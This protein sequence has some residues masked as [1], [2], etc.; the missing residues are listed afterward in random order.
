MQSNN[1]RPCITYE[2]FSKIVGKSCLIDQLRSDIFGCP[3]PRDPKTD[4]ELPNVFSLDEEIQYDSDDERVYMFKGVDVV[5]DV[6]Y[7]QR[8]YLRN[9]EALMAK[10][11]EHLER[12]SKKNVNNAKNDKKKKPNTSEAEVAPENVEAKENVA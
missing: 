10:M 7:G 9:Q 3:R 11:Q 4:I 6:S 5:E 8:G 2:L 1:H 12:Y